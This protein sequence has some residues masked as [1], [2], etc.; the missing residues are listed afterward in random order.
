[1]KILSNNDDRANNFF[2]SYVF[3][4]DQMIGDRPY[5]WACWN[6]PVQGLFFLNI[7]SVISYKCKHFLS[8]HLLANKYPHILH[9]FMQLRLKLSY[10]R[11]IH[12]IHWKPIQKMSV[13]DR[14]GLSFHNFQKML[15]ITNEMAGNFGL[16]ILNYVIF[17]SFEN[18]H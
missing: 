14:H 9:F 7:S 15:F 5:K 4:L 10:K 17:F 6:T 2:R 1:M 8:Y 16:S 11:A 18:F 13:H 3:L 12:M